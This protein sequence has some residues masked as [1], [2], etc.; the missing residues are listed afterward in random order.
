MDIIEIPF[1]A[2]DSELKGWEYT[3]PEGMEAV[4]KDGKVIVRQK[5]SED[6]R[7]RKELLAVIND[8]VLPDEQKARFNAW[9]ERQKEQNNATLQEAFEKSK[10]GFSLEEKRQASDYAES[11]LPTSVTY[12]EI[13]SEYKLH[14]IIEAAFIAGQKE[15]KP[16][17]QHFEKW[18]DS[19]FNE[20]CSP[21]HGLI[22]MNEKEFKN[23]SRGIRNMYQDQ[24]MPEDTVLFNKGVEEGRRLE[25]EDMWKPSEEQPEVDLWKEIHVYFNPYGM[26]LQFDRSKGNTILKPEQLIDFARHFYELGFDARK[27]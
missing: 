24:P 2:K 20:H 14:K 8:L 26:E 15:Q 10:K 16:A 18:L 3:I 17:D 27:K 12:G 6:E 11:I 23:W 7:I 4:I 25:R 13:E 9:L 22:H 1:G 5:E 19:W 21:K